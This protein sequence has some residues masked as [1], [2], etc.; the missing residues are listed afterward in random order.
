MTSE[1]HTQKRPVAKGCRSQTG[2]VKVVVAF[3]EETFDQI[4]NLAVKQGT[5]FAEQ[6]RILTT[7]GMEAEDN[8]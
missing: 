2:R 7:W 1:H 4:H 8:A 5:S 3:D 6:V